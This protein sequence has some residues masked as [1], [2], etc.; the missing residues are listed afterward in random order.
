MAYKSYRLNEKHTT[1]EGYE[2]EIIEYFSSHNCTIQFKDG[3]ILKNK[4]YY[5]IKKGEIRN[6]YH[7]SVYGV[8][9][10][11]EGKYK[12]EV[13]HKPT[14]EYHTWSS[15]IK[16]CHN[17][18]ERDKFPTYKD[19]TITKEWHNFQNFAAWIEDNYNPNIM[20]GWHLDKDI[21][22]KGNKIYSPETCCLVP[23]KINSLFL[24]YENRNNEYPIGVTKESNKFTAKFKNKRLGLFD[25]INEALQAYKVAK[26]AH[27]KEV[28]DLWKDKINPKVYQ[29]MYAYQVEIID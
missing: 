6:P 12:S 4:G 11:G 29:A 2:I 3:T 19:C 24:K 8:G 1:K 14:K 7:K 15:L 27:I 18:K 16:R 23:R 13:N 17:E 28:A 5:S 10:F 20:Q 22:I 26:E 9:Y 21:L 25:T